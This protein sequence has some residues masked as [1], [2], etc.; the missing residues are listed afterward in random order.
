MKRLLLLS[1]LFLVPSAH[2]VDYVK[3]D[4]MVRAFNTV[5]TPPNYD[6]ENYAIRGN[7]CDELGIEPRG[8]KE[9]MDCYH[10]DAS[11]FVE[12]S[13][14]KIREIQAM[15]AAKITADMRAENCPQVD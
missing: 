2:A 3:C 7:Y 6:E 12:N 11:L 14:K 15:K 9:W 1:F 4:A 10:N 13:K 8:G 5:M